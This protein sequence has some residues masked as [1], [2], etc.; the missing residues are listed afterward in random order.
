MT[1]LIGFSPDVEPTTPGVIVDCSQVVPYES[2]LKTAPA[3]VSVGL[4]ALGTPARGAV[5]VR[6]LDGSTRFLVGTTTKLYEAGATTYTDRSRGANYSLGSDDRWS[7]IQFGDTTL[8]AN[9][10]CVLQRSTGAAFADLTAPQAKIVE[11]AKGFA[12]L[13]NT[14]DG[15][16]GTSPDRWWCSATFDETSWTPS[17]TTQCTTGRLVSSP[18]PITAGKRFGDDVIAYKARSLYVGRYQGPPSV[19]DFAA[20]S[21]DVGCVGVEAV[22][23]TPI[24]HVFVGE[25][26]IYVFDGTVPRSLAFGVTKQWFNNNCSPVYRYRSKVLWDRSNS[27][28][29]I[30]FPSSNA[31]ECDS[32][33]VYHTVSKWWGL[34]DQDVAAVVTYTAPGVTYDVGSSIVTTYDAG[35]AISFDSPFWVSGSAVPAFVGTNQLV[36]TLTGESGASW[37]WTGDYGDDEGQS[38]CVGAL[39]RFTLM[40]TTATMLGFVKGEE[41]DPTPSAGTSAAK[42]DGKFDIRQQGRFHSFRCDMTGNAKFTAVRPK[43]KRAGAR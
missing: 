21:Y 28:V 5:L 4:A 20:V 33:I 18:G 8:A 1:P 27:L 36:Y 13:F 42:A 9:L 16:Y 30:F 34:A 41:G 24:G 6:K 38:D 19:W 7:F 11:Q 25:D 22:A 29:W 31:S 14:I 23:D 2:G 39:V 17:V 10:S 26:D 12:M 32:A 40:P 3:A 15:T 35:P 37:F 43:L